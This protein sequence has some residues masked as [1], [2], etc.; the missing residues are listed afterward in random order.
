MMFG[1][2]D[3]GTTNLLTKALAAVGKKMDT[4]PDPTQI[5]YHLPKT[6]AHPDVSRQGA[7][8]HEIVRTHHQKV[9]IQN[10]IQTHQ[11][12]VEKR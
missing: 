2:G 5:H 9:M 12:V 10:T 8:C 6:P 1:F 3:K 4:K 11:Y 7:I